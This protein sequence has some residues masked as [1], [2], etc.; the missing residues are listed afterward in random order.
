MQIR[1][2]ALT[3]SLEPVVDRAQVQVVG[4]GLSATPRF[5][6]ADRTRSQNLAPS[7]SPCS[8]AHSPKTS[9][10]P[11]TVTSKAR[12]TGRLAIWPLRIFTLTASMK[13]TAYTGSNGRLCHSAR[14]SI[15]RSVI[16]VV[17]C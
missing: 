2:W 5:L 10:P 11:S 14:P 4:R 16:V 6:I 15:T 9:R 3:R 8:P 13:I 7:P 1:T 17:V 12:Y